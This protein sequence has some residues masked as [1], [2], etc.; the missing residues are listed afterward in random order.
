MPTCEQ[1]SSLGSTVTESS[2]KYQEIKMLYLIYIEINNFD[3]QNF[4]SIFI[5]AEIAH[6]I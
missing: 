5:L 4:T 3:V 1:A 6:Q 2:W